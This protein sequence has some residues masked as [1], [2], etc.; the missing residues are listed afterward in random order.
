MKATKPK[1]TIKAWAAFSPH[2]G[3]LWFTIQRTKKDTLE[4]F[5]HNWGGSADLKYHPGYS[6]C[7]I[8]I[9]VEE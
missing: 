2:A 9:T 3:L 8:T 4:R 1:K 7:R 5:Q 6:I